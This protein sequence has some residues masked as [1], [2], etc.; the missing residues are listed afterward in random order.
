MLN[1]PINITLEEDKYRHAYSALEAV[2]LKHNTKIGDLSGEARNFRLE[3]LK[4]QEQI[5]TDILA[6]RS[7]IKTPEWKPTLDVE[8]D[9]L[10]TQT[11]DE[12]KIDYR[13][14]DLKILTGKDL[15]DIKGIA[16]PLMDPLEDFTAYTEVDAGGYITVAAN[17]LTATAIPANTNASYVY[18]D[19]GVA[20]FGATWEH[21]YKAHTPALTNNGSSGTVWYLSNNLPHVNGSN[22]AVVHSRFRDIYGAFCFLYGSNSDSVNYPT[23]AASTDYWFTAQRTSETAQQ[24]RIYTDSDRTSLLD[25]LATSL[26]SG[27]RYRYC[28]PIASN[29]RSDGDTI[30]YTV[31][32]LDLQEAAAGGNRRRRLLIGAAA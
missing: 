19:F 16:P 22:D 18:K 6:L 2:R 20:H 9:P 29:D 3:C 1:Y 30:S 7:G 25:T 10:I 28:I 4:V 27:V 5:I 8:I 32:D 11:K 31:S 13:A 14:V 15:D 26:T 21:L 17:L 12:G 24:L 23:I